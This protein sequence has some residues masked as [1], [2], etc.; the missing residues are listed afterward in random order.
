MSL[1]SLTGLPPNQARLRLP[2]TFVESTRAA[3]IREANTEAKR[4]A[5]EH[6]KR[7]ASFLVTRGELAP[8][9]VRGIPGILY[10]ELGRR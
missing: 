1:Y 3:A 7:Q 9:Q 5:A 10:P 6:A 4:A 2:P 8:D